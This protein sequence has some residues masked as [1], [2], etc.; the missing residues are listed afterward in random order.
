MIKLSEIVPLTGLDAICISKDQADGLK[1]CQMGISTSS[2]S[3]SP[4]ALLRA[5]QALYPTELLSAQSGF[6][7][8]MSTET[9]TMITT[10]LHDSLSEL[11]YHMD[12]LEGLIALE[13]AHQYNSRTLDLKSLYQTWNGEPRRMREGRKGKVSPPGDQYQETKKEFHPKRSLESDFR[14]EETQWT[15]TDVHDIDDEF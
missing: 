3:P 4:A 9:R 11:K 1:G 14:L 10:V 12:E 7:D 6:L 2:T 15:A 5:R 13:L 8:A